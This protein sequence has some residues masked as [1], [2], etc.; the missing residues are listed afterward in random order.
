MTV[1]ATNATANSAIFYLNKNSA[2]QSNDLTQLASGSKITSAKD[3][4]SGL[5]I[6]T[7]MGSDASVLQ[8]ASTNL[9]DG[10]AV[11]NTADG[12]YSNISDILT[13]MK[14]LAAEA[15]SGS[16]SSTDIS[17]INTEYQSLFNEINAI[18]QGTTFNGTSLLAGATVAGQAADAN[19]NAYVASPYGT[20]VNFMVGTQASDTISVQLN[21]AGT[22]D[23]LSGNANTA[24][25]GTGLETSLTAANAGAVMTDLSTALAYISNA[26]AGVGALLQRLSFRSDVISTSLQ[27]LDSA[28]SSI[29]DT[30]IA[31]TQTQFSTDQTLTS[32]AVSALS[33]ANQMNQ[34]ILKVLQ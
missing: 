23:L 14:S 29:E 26:R 30:D 32:A 6:A 18:S 27:N 28:K 31:Q 1:I 21:S 16:S 17:Y 2:A 10:T 34:Q 8:Q 11:L 33:D 13:Q 15:Q 24:D 7:G 5:A 19:G 4:P 3:D 22:D 25:G 20:G 12:A 9:Q